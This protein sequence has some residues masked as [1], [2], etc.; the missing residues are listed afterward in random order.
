MP[1]YRPKPEVINSLEAQI[2]KAKDREIIG[3]SNVPA[4]H[5]IGER[6]QNII[7]AHGSKVSGRSYTQP[8]M[9]TAWYENPSLR[10]GNRKVAYRLAQGV[11]TSFYSTNKS[12]FALQVKV[13]EPHPVYSAQQIE[14]EAVIA[15]INADVTH[16]RG[17]AALDG[18]GVCVS[19]ERNV[20]GHILPVALDPD[21][22][23]FQDV[24]DTLD[25]ITT[26]AVTAKTFG[27]PI[28]SQVV[29]L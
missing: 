14:Q 7:E 19:L 27:T 5:A 18:L 20:D 28:T 13:S 3:K 12:L 6:A 1:P 15:Y 24:I 4:H 22:R 17:T 8:E 10:D 21:T 23:E 25:F 29:S 16:V 11:A 9:A 2:Q 26:S